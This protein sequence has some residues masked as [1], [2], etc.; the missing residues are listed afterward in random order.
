MISRPLRARVASI[1]GALA[2]L[3]VVCA[4]SAERHARDADRSATR[5]LEARAADLL[6]G[7]RDGVEWP[8]ERAPSPEAPDDGEAG[9]PGSGDTPASVDADEAVEAEPARRILNLFQALDVAVG[10]NRDFIAR[11]E[12][13][14]LQALSLAETRHAFSPLVSSTLSYL[15]SDGKG[16]PET[17]STAVSGAISQILE[18]GGTLRL[19]ASSSYDTNSAAVNRGSFGSSV[20]VSLIQP[21]LRDAGFEASHE[22]LTQAE[23]NL[24]YAIRDFELFREDFSIDVARR[25]Y[26]LVQQQQSIENEQRNLEE[27]LFGERQAQALFDVGRTAELDVLR[28]RRNRLNAENRL[29]EAEEGYELALDRFRIFLGLADDTKL[30][31][32]A[33]PPDFVPVRYEVRSAVEVAL[34]NRLDFLNRREQLEDGE[35]AVRLARNDLLPSLTLGASLNLPTV[36]DPSF[37][38]QQFDGE[39]VSAGL[40][41]D[42]PV[43]RVAERSAYRR[44]QIALVQA[45][46]AFEEFRD[47]LIVDV[48]SAFRELDRRQESLAIQ[49]QLIDD[50]KKNVRI[51]QLRFE[52]GE[53]PNRDVVEAQ[54]G[55]LDARNALIREQVNYEISRL[56]L[57]RDLGILFI[58]ERGRWTE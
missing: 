4:C 22:A 3:P 26:D 51:A 52:Q 36:T 20:S 7:R 8:E 54:Q 45:R 48:Q 46:R 27:L 58:D 39:S 23:R 30:D 57:L 35:R 41:L 44:T 12:G 38:G 13:L 2:L 6:G 16:L 19:D 34:R 40:T 18:T 21:L 32:A 56:G 28:A 37:T 43:D 25:F 14:F 47:N 29:L 55:L 15:Y 53:I 50:E 17:H 11:K 24:V 1:V 10:S 33:D 42:L 49:R 5:I 31:V 9:A